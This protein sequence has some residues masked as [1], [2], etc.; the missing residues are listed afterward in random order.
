MT[1]H[2]QASLGLALIIGQQWP[3][4]SNRTR[5]SSFLVFV[6]GNATA[7]HASRAALPRATSPSL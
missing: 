3:M 4:V 2:R 5:L 7:L 6:A 1:R